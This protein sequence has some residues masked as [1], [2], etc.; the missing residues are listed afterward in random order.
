SLF[1]PLRRVDVK[2]VEPDPFDDGNECDVP[3]ALMEGSEGGPIAGGLQPPQ[4]RVEIIDGES[5]V[6]ELVSLSERACDR[7]VRRVP[8]ELELVLTVRAP[9]IRELAL[10][11]VRLDS[12]LYLHPEDLREEVN[13]AIE[14]PDAE[15]RVFKFEAHGASIR[16]LWDKVWAALRVHPVRAARREDTHRRCEAEQ[17]SPPDPDLPRW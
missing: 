2:D 1:P 9:E 4:R 10:A 16:N 15:G 14:V 13:R 17:V 3:A 8:V 5:E 12:R 11:P 7:T 6:V